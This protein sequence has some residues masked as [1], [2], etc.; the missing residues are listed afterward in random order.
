LSVTVYAVVHDG[1]STEPLPCAPSDDHAIDPL[2]APP[3]HT[4]EIGVL[5]RSPLSWEWS[6]QPSGNTLCVGV[7]SKSPIPG[8]AADS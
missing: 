6:A 7:V 8:H 2:A 4:P 1:S 5:Q 3:A